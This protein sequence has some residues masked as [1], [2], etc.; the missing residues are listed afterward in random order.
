[1]KII[2]P[3]CRRKFEGSP[4]RAEPRELR[5]EEC[6]RRVVATLAAQA[7]AGAAALAEVPDFSPFAANSDVPGELTRHF[8]V[9]SGVDR[10]NPAW[11]LALL[12]VVGVLAPL[13]LL[14]WLS[15]LPLARPAE[16]HPGAKPVDAPFFS[17]S[18][19]EGLSEQLL[20]KPA[21]TDLP[22]TDLP[23]T[24][25]LAP[26][27]PAPRRVAR[28]ART[29]P[30]RARGLSL[31]DFYAAEPQRKDAIPRARGVAVA[32]ADKDSG[33]LEDGA[34]AKVVAQSQAAFQ[35]CIEQALKRNPNLKIGK[36]SM[37]LTVG[38]S[39]KVT[40]ALIDPQEEDGSEW[41]ACVKD[42]A[43]RMVFPK[44]ESDA[45]TDLHIPLLVGVAH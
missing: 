15:S 30:E 43:R 29:E 1:M 44:S 5:C 36:V 40:G 6:Q 34:A 42:R 39:G 17:A 21:P 31:T 4:D 28:T 7:R 12:A 26:P 35:G 25:A 23:P 8:I 38:P 33:G 24:N 3:R 9:Q 19:V 32:D 10:R 45:E 20:G 14:G 41:G 2:C 37:T 13:G 11:K 16:P 18:S 27:E 22:P